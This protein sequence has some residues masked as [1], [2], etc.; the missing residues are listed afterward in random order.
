MDHILSSFN[1]LGT[2]SERDTERLPISLTSSLMVAT[3]VEVLDISF[4]KNSVS[5]ENVNENHDGGENRQDIKYCEGHT[6]EG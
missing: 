5:A 2:E 3:E 6:I 4:T 1:P